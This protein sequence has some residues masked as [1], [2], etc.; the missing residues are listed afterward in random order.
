MVLP[1]LC[2][3]YKWSYIICGICA[4][5]LSLSTIVSFW[6]S[7]CFI[8]I[9]YILLHFPITIY[10]PY[11]LFCLHPPQHNTFKFLLCCSMHQY[12]TCFYSLTSY[13]YIPPC[14]WFH[15]LQFQLLA[16]NYG[17]KNIKW[18]IAEITIH[19]F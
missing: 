3:T 16:I 7:L 18:E 13:I 6:D 2:I 10:V 4:W 14:L 17:L 8:F 12:F 1:I 5:L 15:F 9:V 19:K 11:T